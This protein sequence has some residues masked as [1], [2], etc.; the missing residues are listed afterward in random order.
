MVHTYSLTISL[1]ILG[2]HSMDEA[3]WTEYMD[4]PIAPPH[5]G[6]GDRGQGTNRL[7]WSYI[8]QRRNA[9]MQCVHDLRICILVFLLLLL[10][11]IFVSFSTAECSLQT[12]GDLCESGQ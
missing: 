6:V 1:Y 12:A 9:L 4:R 8:S 3:L 2:R 7:L 10:L 11:V 5:L